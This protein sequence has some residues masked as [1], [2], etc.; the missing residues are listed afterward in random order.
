MLIEEIRKAFLDGA[1]VEYTSHCQRRMFERDISKDDIEKTILNGEIIEDYPLDESNV[2]EKSY[3]ACLILWI[4]TEKQGAIHVVL[5]F[6]GVRIII[7]SAY[8]PSA[9]FW[10]KDYRTR[11]GK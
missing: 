5:A 2:S 3:P 7:I 1:P 10:E 9:L 6:N 4:D 8:F 11:K